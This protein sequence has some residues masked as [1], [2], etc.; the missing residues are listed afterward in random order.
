MSWTH[1]LVDVWISLLLGPHSEIGVEANCFG[2]PDRQGKTSW[3]NAESLTRF[4]CIFTY[5]TNRQLV[6]AVQLRQLPLI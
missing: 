6:N 1:L 2:L 3:G 4:G 5:L